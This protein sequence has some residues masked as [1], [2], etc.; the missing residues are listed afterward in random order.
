MHPASSAGPINP[1]IYKVAFLKSLWYSTKVHFVVKIRLPTQI[2][3]TRSGQRNYSLF[4]IV[5][6]SSF[7][8][9]L[10]PG[11][12]YF[13]SGYYF[14]PL[15]AVAHIVVLKAY[16]YLTRWFSARRLTF[17]GLAHLSFIAFMVLQLESIRGEAMPTVSWFVNL[18]F[19]IH[20]EFLI[21]TVQD[22]FW[23]YHNIFL[24]IILGTSYLIMLA[25]GLVATIITKNKPHR[26]AENLDK[27]DT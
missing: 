22:P 19:G 9:T 7:F 27:T 4:T 16:Y 11:D 3:F 24:M 20:T 8:R 21:Q 6:L 12:A 14:I 1:T 13:A 5:L 18:W 23:N 25:A 26:P 17:S 15:T 10:V 2:A